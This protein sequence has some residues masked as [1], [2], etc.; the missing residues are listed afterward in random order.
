MTSSI[1]KVTATEPV[2]NFSL[3]TDKISFLKTSIQN[4]AK[5]PKN[6]CGIYLTRIPN[7][8][9]LKTIK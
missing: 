9:I 5:F 7:G 1:L 6:L 2:L 4:G 8:V 3:C